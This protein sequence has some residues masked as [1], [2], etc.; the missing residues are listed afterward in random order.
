M[1][2]RGLLILVLLVAPVLV[3]PLA[4]ATA[5]PTPDEELATASEKLFR[6]TNDPKAHLA[7]ARAYFRRGRE[8]DPQRVYAHVR[9]AVEISPGVESDAMV[10]LRSTPAGF[11]PQPRNDAQRILDERV[12]TTIPTT[13]RSDDAEA[14]RDSNEIISAGLAARMARRSF[15]QASDDP[16]KN[17]SEL[18]VTFGLAG[19]SSE[20]A[21]WNERLSAFEGQSPLGSATWRAAYRQALVRAARQTSEFRVATAANLRGTAAAGDEDFPDP[22]VT[23]NEAYAAYMEGE[24]ER[25]VDLMLKAVSAAE[26]L[27]QRRM[28]GAEV[29]FLPRAASDVGQ[30]FVPVGTPVESGTP[31]PESDTPQPTGGTPQPAPGAPQDPPAPVLPPGTNRQIADVALESVEAIRNEEVTPEEATEKL[32]ELAAVGTTCEPLV[33]DLDGDG[34]PA[35][36]GGLLPD[37]AMDGTP[38]R[39][40]LDGDG[41]AE[42]VEWVTGRDGLLFVDL[43][44]D[45]LATWGGELFGTALGDRDGFERLARFDVDAD[46]RVAGP[47][48]AGLRLWI[49]D[50]DGRCTSKEVVTLDAVGIRSLSCRPDGLVG[51]AATDQ[52]HLTVWE[53]M[54][55]IRP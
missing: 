13:L 31:P 55:D 36:A 8:G 29:A 4:A 39:F 45:G 32:T 7:V 18:K 50:G 20:R 15:R 12:E 52:G 42:L 23:K 44:G 5:T 6:S 46:G 35:L 16:E 49:D 41:H 17:L 53:W 26:A 33:V 25:A 14:P 40:D 28:T 54:P 9:R 19:E 11:A 38:V 24:T 37:G 34:C 10:L 1:T 22:I 2:H 48:A 21:Q 30:A 3:S 27:E 51:S 47:E 43:D